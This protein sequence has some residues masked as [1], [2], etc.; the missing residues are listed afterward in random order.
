MSTFVT[1]TDDKISNRIKAATRRIVLVAPAVSK[2]VATAFE[3]CL[4]KA[5]KV[6]VTLVLDPD[7]DAYRIGY[8]EREGLEQLEI[9]AGKYSLS[10]RSQP[11]LRIGL[12]LVDDDVLVW[13]PTPR[14]VEGQRAEEEQNGVDLGG[15]LDAVDHLT[16]LDKGEESTGIRSSFADVIQDAV[17]NDDSGLFPN[18]AEIGHEALKPEQ[19]RETINVLIENPPAPFD[20]AQKTRVFS[21]KFQFVETEVR[22]VEWTKREIK[23]STLLLNPD[24]PDE[25]QDLFETRIKPFS[26]KGDLPIEVPTLV[27]GQVAY[28][29]EGK[30]IM[31]FM[32]QAD[33]DKAW[34]ELRGRYLRQ[35]TGFG[36]LISK[37]DKKRFKADV[38]AYKDVLSDWVEGFREKVGNDQ[39]A[40]V[41]EI[42]GMIMGR[43]GRSQAKK[44]I[45]SEEE[46][47]AI[48]VAGIQKLRV[49]EPNV[50]L[51]F[52]EISWES[53]RDDEFTKAL[54]KEFTNE[55]LSKWFSEFIAVPQVA[56]H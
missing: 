36:W 32:T 12:L 33:I 23:L 19:M 48:V 55:E 35:L 30:E 15:G 51:I 41:E 16:P 39:K 24:L 49:T 26:R 22:G 46:I 40:L 6:N 31:S 54:E 50:K 10:L 5:E 1:V 7:E 38:A 44:K 56:P 3:Q 28:N 17:G 52:K 25:L 43:M 29:S 45:T 4:Q 34:K 14:A 8:G 37:S 2:L 21:T 9:L 53:S 11:G 18:L 47:K 13:S 27:H 42:V 20:L